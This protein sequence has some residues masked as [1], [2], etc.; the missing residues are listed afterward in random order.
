MTPY[1]ENA[2]GR[3]Y[4][5]PSIVKQAILPEV[6]G[7][8]IFRPMGSTSDMREGQM[9]IPRSLEKGIKLTAEAGKVSATVS[10]G[11][12]YGTCIWDEATKLQKNVRRAIESKTGLKVEDICLSV[13]RVFTE[14][15][16]EPD[17]EVKE[18]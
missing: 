10:V 4:V 17:Q 13:E 5:G 6:M 8:K 11:V 2:L 15:D 12:Q 9:P 14:L 16:E 18:E 7:S 3:V 1:Y